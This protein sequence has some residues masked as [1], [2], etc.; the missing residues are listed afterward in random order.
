MEFNLSK[1][2]HLFAGFMLFLSLF[3][4][5]GMP[6][7]S[8]FGIISSSS[9]S[10]DPF[11]GLPELVKIIAELFVLGLQVIL[12]VLFFIL[13][14]YIWYKLVNHLNLKEMMDAILLKREGIQMA[15]LWGVIG[16][17]ISFGI[18]IALGVIFT[19]LGFDIQNASN[20][21]DLEK[22]FP[23][24]AILFLITFQPIAEEIFFRGF[25]L[26]KLTKVANIPVAVLISSLFFGIAHLL[27]GNPYPALITGVIGIVFAVLVIKT[28]NLYS[29]IFAH[30]I[31]NITNFLFYLLGKMILR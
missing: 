20:I 22:L 16:A 27:A 13:V 10:T 23:L 28:K 5:I 15:V 30:I 4:F 3:I 8:Y 31:F 19:V 1:P 24:P 11:S 2:T 26:E 7:L 18:V 6:L 17:I 21:T 9:G 14:P 25:L 29:S 12:V